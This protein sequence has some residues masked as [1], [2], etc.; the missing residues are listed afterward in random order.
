MFGM[1]L[2]ALIRRR[3]SNWLHVSSIL[4]IPTRSQWCNGSIAVSK[5]VGRGSNP[6]WGANL[7]L[8]MNLNELE[9]DE[10]ALICYIDT[11][12]HNIKELTRLM[13]MG[14][15]GGLEIRKL[16]E[17]ATCAEYRVEG[18]S[19]RLVIDKCLADYIIIELLDE[20]IE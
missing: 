16:G 20:A 18:C 8:S 4:I 13:T 10:L 17:V 19:S 12:E 1:Y 9:I 14:V 2:L 3:K 6:C 7:R 15:V 11:Q 5:T